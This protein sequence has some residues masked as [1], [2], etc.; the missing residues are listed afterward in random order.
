[1]C[2][3]VVLKVLTVLVGVTDTGAGCAGG[4]GLVD[5]LT[6]DVEGAFG[7]GQGLH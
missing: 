4:G 7:A 1:M 3:I 5:A 6:Q 2:R